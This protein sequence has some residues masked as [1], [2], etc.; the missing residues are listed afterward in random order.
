MSLNTNQLGELKAGLESI[1]DHM[2]TMQETRD[3]IKVLKKQLKTSLGLEPKVVSRL[4]KALYAQSFTE[5]VSA[6]KVF[7]D[8][9]MQVTGKNA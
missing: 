4:A 6:D 2:S 1:V 8:L 3:S 9:Y 7:V 5:E